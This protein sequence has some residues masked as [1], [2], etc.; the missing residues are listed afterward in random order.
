MH[1]VIDGVRTF[2]TAIKGAP[3]ARRGGV[4]RKSRATR[5]ATPSTVRELAT[6]GECMLARSSARV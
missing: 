5:K 4:S 3:E 6:T 1:V 2:F